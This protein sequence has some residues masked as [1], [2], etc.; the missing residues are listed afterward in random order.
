M[1]KYEV[2]EGDHFCYVSSWYTYYEAVNEA[3]RLNNKYNRDFF[4]RKRLDDG[5]YLRKR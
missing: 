5:T 1:V 2:W 4:V 3:N